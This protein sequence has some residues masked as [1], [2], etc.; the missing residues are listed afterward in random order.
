[1]YLSEI[2]MY[3]SE[4]LMYLSEIRMYLSEILMYLSEILMYH[5]HHLCETC[6]SSRHNTKIW[7]KYC[8]FLTEVL[9]KI[10]NSKFKI[11][12][13]LSGKQYHKPVENT[14][15]LLVPPRLAAVWMPLGWMSARPGVAWFGR[16]HS[17]MLGARTPRYTGASLERNRISVSHRKFAYVANFFVDATLE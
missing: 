5:A 15:F 2:L 17:V 8:T 13:Y 1:M 16:E 10:Q 6:I 9:W 3:L 4:I 12:M 7:F 14:N 11:V